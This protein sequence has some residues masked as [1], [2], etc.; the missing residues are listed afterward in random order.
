MPQTDAPIDRRGEY[1][2]VQT[3]LEGRGGD[4]RGGTEVRRQRGLRRMHAHRTQRRLMS[5]KVLQQAL[6]IA[7]ALT[8][9]ERTV[10]GRD[11]E[12]VF[13]P[14]GDASDGDFVGT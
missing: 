12:G 14:E 1:E 7:M 3:V 5:S 11:E 4:A 6:A 13:V 8:G 2:I 9:E 10:F